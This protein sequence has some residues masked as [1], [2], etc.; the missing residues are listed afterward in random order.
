MLMM[1]STGIYDGGDGG[2]G[3]LGGD[4]DLLHDLHLLLSSCKV[5]LQAGI[6]SRT[7]LELE[8]FG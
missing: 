6:L 4:D 3:T 2:D 1:L 7:K 5:F 8:T